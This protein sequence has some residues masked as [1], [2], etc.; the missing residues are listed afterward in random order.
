MEE[1]EEEILMN[2]QLKGEKMYDNYIAI[3]WAQKNMAVSR[4]THKSNYIKTMETRSDVGDLCVYLKN[5]Q[6]STILT[7]EE[8]STSQWL[9]SE[10][11][12]SIDKIVI[13]DPYRNHLLKEGP[14]TDKI[15]SQKLV[16]LLRSGLLKPVYHSND[17]FIYLRKIVSGYEDVVKAGVRAKNQ[18]SSLFRSSHLDYKKQDCLARSEDKFVLEGLDRAIESYAE[19]KKRYEQEFKRMS[20]KHKEIRHLMSVPGLGLINSVKVVARVVDPHRFERGNW[21]SYCGLVK[22]HKMSGGRSYGTRRSRYSHQMKGV[23]KTATLAVIRGNN[24]FNDYYNKLMTEKNYP[25][26]KARSAVAKRIASICLGVLKTG[27]KYKP[28]KERKTDIDNKTS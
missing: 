25:A 15:D 24:E 20:K 8:T 11:R 16:Y 4:M 23:F 6:G 17:D 7:I 2:N 19:E 10:L 13:C 28:Y 1:E 26:Y 18:K 14:K 21:W 3:D 5:L 12:K 9:Y 22:L 27:K